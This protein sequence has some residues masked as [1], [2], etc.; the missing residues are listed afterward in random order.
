MLAIE[1]VKLEARTTPLMPDFVALVD[2]ARSRLHVPAESVPVGRWAGVVGFLAPRIGEAAA[3][4]IES[5]LTQSDTLFSPSYFQYCLR[6]VIESIRQ[7]EGDEHFVAQFA[8]QNRNLLYPDGSLQWCEVFLVQTPEDIR[9]ST[10]KAPTEQIVAESVRPIAERRALFEAFVNDLLHSGIQI[11]LFLP[12]P[13]PWL[14]AEAEHELQKSGKTCPTAET[15]AYLRG[16]AKQHGIRVRGSY[17]PQR[18][19]VTESDFVDLVHLRREAIDR[20]WSREV[21]TS[22]K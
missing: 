15:E 22:S 6:L 14:Y 4:D 18:A 5:V 1:P 16:F 7:G 19:G 10:G 11:E 8:K 20:I 21:P 3:S 9:R 17:D 13:N 12:P 2:K